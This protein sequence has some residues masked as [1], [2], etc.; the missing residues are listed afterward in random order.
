MI[1]S[2]APILMIAVISLINAVGMVVASH[3]LNPYRPT[4]V[5]SAPYESGIVP[6]GDTRERFSVKFYMVAILFIVFDLETVLLIPWAVAMRVLG[7]EGFIA[8]MIFLTV[9]TVG[10]IYEWKKGALQWD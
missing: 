5:K 6:L 2:Y 4:P 9:L 8:V 3:L 7:W 10:L 1:E